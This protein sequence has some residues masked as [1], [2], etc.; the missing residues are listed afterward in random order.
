MVT[1]L[2]SIVLV[3]WL[4]VCWAFWVLSSWAIVA[5]VH[6]GLAIQEVDV[7]PATKQPTKQSTKQSTADTTNPANTKHAPSSSHRTDETPT[8]TDVDT[9]IVDTVIDAR[10][11]RKQYGDFTAVSDI[12]FSVARGS[13]FGMLGPNGAGKTTTMRMVYR[14]TPITA[15]HLTILG[16]EAG[17][18]DRAIKARLGVVPQIDN[19]D[20]EL[21]VLENLLIYAR[22]HNITGETA[23]Q[24]ALELLDFL[25]LSGKKHA[26]VRSLSGG[27]KRRLTLARGLM[28]DP[29]IVILDEP[30]TGLDPQV[31]VTLW[32]KLEELRSRGVTLVMSTHYMDEAERLCDHLV[33]M[34][35]GHIVSR[36]GP[37]DM[38]AQHASRDVLEG[39]LEAPDEPAFTA[40]VKQHDLAA[41]RT[42]E[43]VSIF[44]SD[45][46][47]ILSELEQAGVRLVRPFV[48]PGNLEDVFLNLTGRSLRE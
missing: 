15:G 40:F 25:E 38:V 13:F 4:L 6:A 28:N 26:D 29:E 20:E 39:R 12:D 9:V 2:M 1:S 32:D 14:V 7:T 36:G 10:G 16:L 46:R 17:Q 8:D 47:Q 3:S 43:R 21:N 42:S 31:R 34:D 19:L 33:I 23:K 35:D 48:R 5:K 27:M 18:D 44:A 41:V 30:T 24:R 22:Y 11:L 37:R 45:G